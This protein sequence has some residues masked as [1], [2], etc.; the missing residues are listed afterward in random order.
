MGVVVFTRNSK[1]VINHVFSI[2]TFLVAYC[3]LVNLYINVSE[4]ANEVYALLNLVSLRLFV[5]PLSVHFYLLLTDQKHILKGY[6]IYILLYLFPSIMVFTADPKGLFY[7][8]DLGHGFGW[9]FF[10]KETLRGTMVAI[11]I[12]ALTLLLLYMGIRHVVKARDKVQKHQ[13]RLVLAGFIVSLVFPVVLDIVLPM[14]PVEVPQTFPATFILG[15]SLIALAIIK[16]E[17]F[18]ATPESAAEDIL[19][20][21]DNAVIITSKYGNI[22]FGNQASLDMFEMSGERFS[23]ADVNELFE[24]PLLDENFEPIK[25]SN[26]NKIKRDGGRTIHVMVSHTPL[27]QQNG[28]INGFA[29]VIREITELRNLID[30]IGESESRYKNIF[31]NIQSVYFESSIDG[32]ILEVSPSITMYTSYKRQDLIGKPTSILYAD[33]NSR[34]Q[35]VQHLMTS[36]EQIMFET[37][38]MDKD[39]R[40][41]HCVL[42]MRM[43]RKNGV[44]YKVVGTITN[45]EN[46]KEAE[47]K[48]AESEERYR[49]LYEKSPNGI[50]LA[51]NLFQTISANKAAY[52]LLGVSDQN[53]LVNQSLLPFIHPD[54]RDEMIRRARQRASGIAV[55]NKA[56]V[57]ILR[58]NGETRHLEYLVHELRLGDENYMLIILHDLTEVRQAEINIRR[59]EEKYR[60]FL[61]NFQGIA[62]RMKLDGSLEFLYGDVFGIT[63]YT[64]DE[65][66]SGIPIIWRII[67]HEDRLQIFKAVRMLRSIPNSRITIECRILHRN[68]FPKYLRL[69]LQNLMDENGA[70]SYIQAAM[71][72]K[73]DYYNLQNQIIN[74]II[75]TEDRER[76][77]FAEDLHDELGPLLSS[78]RIYINL[79]Q[80]KTPEQ[81]KERSELIEF[82]KQ[83]LDEAVQQTK[84]ISYNL[85]PEV[86]SQYGI[87]PSIKAFCTKTNIAN[88]VNINLITEEV[89]EERRFDTK[90]EL[91]IYRVVKELIHNTLKHAK[92]SNIVIKFGVQNNQP[93]LEYSDDG[94]GFDLE[95]KMAQS[96]TLGVRNIFHRIQSVDGTVNFTSA[97]DKGTKVIIR[98]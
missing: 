91:A 57:R 20:S 54:D 97:P 44:P 12:M 73:S 79:I 69:Y 24:N 82:A 22:T 87:I 53:E 85:M 92:A 40:A 42:N 14:M 43:L 36:D 17:L 48:L 86:L 51:K 5:F 98:F 28:R 64:I 78:V 61:E 58:N 80:T 75:E 76:S 45:I 96:T 49:L 83:L 13:S 18:S 3:S 71:F 16:Y 81:E 31:E 65:F 6:W 23:K 52:D 46:L 37:R 55:L 8:K 70:P 25:G 62:F 1:H 10:L 21:I 2:M 47:R 4:S 90:I 33:D 84:S 95:S 7:V 77:R 29:F 88:R 68:G 72:D 74:S 50:I 9:S 94:I 67:H 66:Y 93:I 63:G 15:Y 27:R 34:Q 30:R 60:L 35:I 19:K 39:G 56:E 59:N 11:F 89:D 38:L 32:T 26:E 41:D